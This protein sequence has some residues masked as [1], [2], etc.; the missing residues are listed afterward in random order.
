M[1]NGQT[2]ALPQLPPNE[3][4]YIRNLSEKTSITSLKRELLQLFAKYGC[5]EIVAHKNVRMRGQ[6]FVVFETIPEAE[7]ALKDLQGYPIDDKAMLIQFAKSKS[8][9][10]VQHNNPAALEQH[11]A[12]RLARKEARGPLKAATSNKRSTKRAANA[13]ASATDANPPHKILLV[14][15]LPEDITNDVMQAVFG[16]F[17]GFRDI[18]MVPGRNLAFVEYTDDAAA[19]EAKESTNGVTISEQQLRVTYGKKV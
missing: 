19:M 10:V 4:I 18:R 8:D 13:K 9:R 12:E 14:Q 16:R 5:K 2:V 3:T 15:N 7:K 17:A 11:K 1:S 6:A